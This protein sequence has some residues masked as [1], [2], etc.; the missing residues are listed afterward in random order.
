MQRLFTLPITL[1]LYLKSKPHDV[2]E[3]PEKCPRCQKPGLN[4][5][6]HYQRLMVLWEQVLELKVARF[7]VRIAGEL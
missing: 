2:V 7:C 4:R 1:G 6:G 5:H 3:R